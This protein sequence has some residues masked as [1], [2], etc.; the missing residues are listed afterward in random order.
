M[1]EL[2]I[3][4]WGGGVNTDGD[5]TCGHI[6]GNSAFPETD[7]TFNQINPHPPEPLPTIHPPQSVHL[8]QSRLQFWPDIPVILETCASRKCVSISWTEN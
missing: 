3:T 5:N 6:G 1:A 8:A 7:K 2:R 4:L